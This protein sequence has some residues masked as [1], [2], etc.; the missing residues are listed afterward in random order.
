MGAVENHL[1]ISYIRNGFVKKIQPED[2][3]S[4]EAGPVL[5]TGA[6]KTGDQSLNIPV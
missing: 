5:L 4:S 1:L 3:P 6:G 2:T